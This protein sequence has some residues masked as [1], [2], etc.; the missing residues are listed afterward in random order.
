MLQQN[1]V[2]L[3]EALDA[4]LDARER[5][6]KVIDHLMADIEK[7]RT[8]IAEELLDIGRTEETKTI[9]MEII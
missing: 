3:T 8:Q 6:D 7:T 9:K 4:L 2:V 5:M 1:K